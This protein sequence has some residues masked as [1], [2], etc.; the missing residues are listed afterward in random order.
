MKAKSAVLHRGFGDSRVNGAGA[1]HCRPLPAFGA[2]RATILINQS[3]TMARI[4]QADP[5]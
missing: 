1:L 3:V 2:M 4:R 5:N